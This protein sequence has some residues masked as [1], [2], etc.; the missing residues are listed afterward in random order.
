M[1]FLRASLA[2]LETLEPAV[3]RFLPEHT[4]PSRVDALASDLAS[5]DVAG[6]D[7]AVVTPTIANL[8]D[9][10]G[11]AYVMEGSALGGMVLARRVDAGLSLGGRSLR[12]LTLRGT[13]TGTAWKRFIAE[14][15]TWGRTASPAERAR[16]ID[17]AIATFAAY[18]DACA[19]YGAITPSCES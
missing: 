17:V 19:K 12:Y 11:A 1:A 3:A 7:A 10:Y 14:L 6:P 2:V 5:L 15:D 13:E 4:G 16:S 8:A 9:A 18:A